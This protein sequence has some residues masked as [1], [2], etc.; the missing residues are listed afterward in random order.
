M[1]DF[2]QGLLSVSEDRETSVMNCAGAFKPAWDCCRWACTLTAL[3]V[4]LG[5][6]LQR[7]REAGSDTQ[8]RD[9]GAHGLLRR[10]RAAAF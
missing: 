2:S 7:E 1:E 5:I 10:L 9:R 6:I 4:S 8:Q 3:T